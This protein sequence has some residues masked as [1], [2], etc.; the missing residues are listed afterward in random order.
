MGGEEFA[1]L[2]RGVNAAQALPIVERLRAGVQRIQF[3]IPLHGAWAWPR[4]QTR[5][6]T[7]MASCGPLTP[8]S[9]TR[10]A[11][12]EPDHDRRLGPDFRH[13]GVLERAGFGRHAEPWPR[14][15]VRVP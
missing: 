4:G 3:R 1:V 14:G 10:S 11:S 13:H 5:R 7:A 12:A 9:T 6:P 15:T 2:F 8:C